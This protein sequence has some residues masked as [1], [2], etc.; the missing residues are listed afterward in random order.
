[1]IVPEYRLQEWASC[2]LL[3]LEPFLPPM[4]SCAFKAAQWLLLEAFEGRI[5]P[6]YVLRN[7]FTYFW[8]AEWGDKPHEGDDYWAGPRAGRTIAHRLFE[9][10]QDYE[11]LRPVQPYR[12]EALGMHGI[13]GQ[14]ALIRKRSHRSVDRRPMV[15]MLEML[16]KKY[17]SQ[18][19]LTEIA[20]VCHQLQECQYPEVGVYHLPL[21][22]TRVTHAW[23]Q[24]EI[25]EALG[26]R[27]LQSILE[28]MANQHTYP[29]R[30]A[31]CRQCVSQRCQ[32]VYC[33]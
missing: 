15:L 5:I 30:G 31:H 28:A 4:H 9:L 14:Y 33:V 19:D 26:R 12:L 21:L 2:P 16:Q 8:N 27:W 7:K 13:E 18:P 11:V 20:R 25:N 6:A 17:Q 23:Q 32:A 24:L 29:N 3:D 10:I 1:M 22:G